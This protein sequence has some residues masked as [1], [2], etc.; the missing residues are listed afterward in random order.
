MV[1]TEVLCVTTRKSS[2]EED[3]DRKVPNRKEGGGK[4]NILMQRKGI[5]GRQGPVDRFEMI[6]KLLK[7][8]AHCNPLSA[9]S[10]TSS[11]EWTST[12]AR[13]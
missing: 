1:L 11:P 10:H 13:D 8:D 6:R 7:S 9:V 4:R 5:T 3:L 2:L 12:D